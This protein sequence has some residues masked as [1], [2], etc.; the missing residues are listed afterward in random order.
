MERIIT[1]RLSSFA[2]RLGFFCFCFF[3][4]NIPFVREKDRSVMLATTP[5]SGNKDTFNLARVSLVVK[6]MLCLATPT[7]GFATLGF[8]ALSHA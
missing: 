7:L 1:N 6:G 3:S 5:R 8:A 4:H 2:K